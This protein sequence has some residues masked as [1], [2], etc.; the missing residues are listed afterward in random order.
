VA[1]NFSGE[2]ISVPLTDPATTSLDWE[3]RYSTVASGRLPVE[4]LVLRLAAHEAAI[5]RAPLAEAPSGG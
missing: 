1:I 2:A 3:L 4:G 5:L